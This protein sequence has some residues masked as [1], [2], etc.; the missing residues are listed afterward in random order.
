MADVKNLTKKQLNAI[1][2]IA[3]GKGGNKE[4]AVVHA[5]Y[6]DC[7]GKFVALDNYHLAVFDD[8][9]EDD[10]A[11]ISGNADTYTFY[12]NGKF[13]NGRDL[14]DH[15]F[16]M[17]NWYE[18][19]DSG[20]GVYSE[21]AKEF[22]TAKDVDEWCSDAVVIGGHRCVVRKVNGYDFGVNAT[23]LKAVC[24]AL[25]VRNG[26]FVIYYSMNGIIVWGNRGC[27]MVMPVRL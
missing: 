5:C 22:A 12:E 27:G 24:N 17:R 11:E 6:F 3:S 16:V 25:G 4:K 20:K 9:T 26:K 14:P 13:P 1:K 8:M 21:D 2:S 15:K 18:Y 19:L 10:V 7:N 23:Y